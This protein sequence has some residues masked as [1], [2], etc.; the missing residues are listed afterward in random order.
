MGH[1]QFRRGFKMEA[2]RL[3]R[4]RGEHGADGAGGGWRHVR[5]KYSPEH[6]LTGSQ[7]SLVAGAHNHLYRTRFHALARR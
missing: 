5:T 6:G 4:E 7:L 1:R 2:V 3:I